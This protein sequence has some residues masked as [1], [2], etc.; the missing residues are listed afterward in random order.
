MRL[1]LGLLVSTYRPRQGSEVVV[2]G[3]QK[4]LGMDKKPDAPK[5]DSD[6]P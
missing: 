2:P 4:W 5:H 3:P 1:R 6:A